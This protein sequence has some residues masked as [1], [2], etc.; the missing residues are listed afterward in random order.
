MCFAENEED[1]PWTPLHVD[2]GLNK[3]DSAISL[4]FVT[5]SAHV[6]SPKNS[7]FDDKMAIDC[8]TQNVVGNYAGGHGMG[9]ASCLFA[10]T[11]GCAKQFDHYG[12]TKEKIMSHLLEAGKKAPRADWVKR[13]EGTWSP[14]EEGLRLVVAGGT[15]AY[16]TAYQLNGG[17]G[18]WMTKKI[19]LPKNWQQLIKKYNVLPGYD[20][21]LK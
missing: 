4:F 14:P 11:S 10:V 9:G 21:K 3:E 15:L 16:N 2:H 6:L 18:G 17:F 13:Y 19:D 20:L 8:M 5:G 7:F 12:W 1:S